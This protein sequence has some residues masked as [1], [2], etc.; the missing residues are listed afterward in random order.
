MKKT[1][2]TVLCAL[3]LLSSCRQAPAQ[4]GTQSSLLAA[5]PAHNIEPLKTVQG[6]EPETRSDE[7]ILADAAQA[8]EDFE[9]LFP[10]ASFKTDKTK[11]V[12]LVYTG[13]AAELSVTDDAGLT[14]TL[15]IPEGALAK[16]TTI[17]MTPLVGISDGIGKRSG[18]LFEPDGLIFTEPASLS[19]TGTNADKALLLYADK[20]GRDMM[21]AGFSSGK[22]TE[23]P[24]FHFSTAFADAFTSPEKLAEFQAVA[25]KLYGDY[26][27]KARTLL[28]KQIKPSK[29]M[30]L[31]LACYEVEDGSKGIKAEVQRAVQ[32]E[33]NY[34]VALYI[35]LGKAI[36]NGETALAKELN[37][38]IQG[39]TERA[40]Q[41]LEML[42]SLDNP[43]PETYFYAY[44]S[45]EL[46]MG[47]IA[48]ST[49]AYTGDLDSI[50]GDPRDQGKD[51]LKTFIIKVH[52]AGEYT[53]KFL[54]DGIIE[55]HEYRYIYTAII[56]EVMLSQTS[57]AAS[58]AE[59]ETVTA[60]EHRRQQL[61]N[62]CTFTV[63]FEGTTTQ[64]RDSTATWTT[65]GEGKLC[66]EQFL[67]D[68]TVE[69]FLMFKGTAQG[70]HDQ[71]SS[72]DPA[73]VKTL[74]TKEFETDVHL[75]LE[76]PCCL[77][78][79][80]GVSRFGADELTYQSDD[81]PITAPSF[82]NLINQL[83]LGEYYDVQLQAVMADMKLAPGK[84]IFEK[85]IDGKHEYTTIEYT[86][87]LEHTPQQSNGQ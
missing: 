26:Y 3:L 50:K 18:V 38:V 65:S 61:S 5:S 77:S 42:I 85:K 33:I 58:A 81:G 86:I 69:G 47:L 51:R 52:K 21:P 40:F 4:T 34:S 9:S 31:K 13:D 54:L 44:N 53:W 35:V 75:A 6:N 16:Q 41:K 79:W 63:Y 48:I 29:P 57:R 8:R 7:D 64:K 19:V 22:S 27:D 45:M 82:Y 49:M 32:E 74:L 36:M 24:L 23:V 62:A 39:L 43:K 12:S 46:Q 84:Y 73:A 37:R 17:S 10:D 78:A 59:N 55:D 83:A 28:D 87:F 2:T 80:A 66:L 68:E 60:D 71:Y 70:I 1:V 25:D 67:G 15:S 72:T 11:T 30:S 14:W 56:A 20:K 76:L